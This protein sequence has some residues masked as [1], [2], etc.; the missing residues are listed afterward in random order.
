MSRAITSIR[1]ARP[2]MIS[3]SKVSRTSWRRMNSAAARI[4]LAIGSVIITT[5]QGRL[6]TVPSGQVVQ[7][8]LRLVHHPRSL[9]APEGVD[10]PI[11]Q[12]GTPGTETPGSLG[13]VV[14]FL[15]HFQELLRQLITV[16]HHS[17][18]PS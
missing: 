18:H 1:S 17:T 13:H 14:Q 8:R 6:I 11:G 10:E 2:T 15:R 3:S 12:G 16:G 5:L 4:L 9:A 7:V